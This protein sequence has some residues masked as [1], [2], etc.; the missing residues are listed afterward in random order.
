VNHGNGNL[1]PRTIETGPQLGDMVIVLKGLKAGEQVVS[2]ANF[3]VDSE[4]QLQAAVGA[5]APAAPQPAAGAAPAAQIQID[6]STQPSPPHIG[7]NAVRV[8]L[9]GTD[10]KPVAGAQVKAIFFMPAMP[11]M[12]MAASR[13]TAALAEKGNGLYE[14]ALQLESGGTWQVSVSVQR[15]GQ[16]IATKQLSVDAAGGM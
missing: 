2:S 8:K 12:G 11:A 16:T 13:A 7:A 5:F 14:G 3:L 6:F 10:G 1:E 9:T 15:G 4:A